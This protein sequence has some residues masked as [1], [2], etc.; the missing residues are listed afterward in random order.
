MVHLFKSDS[1]AT[2]F[3][4]RG[5]SKFYK[6]FIILEQILMKRTHIFTFKIISR[7]ISIYKLPNSFSSR[8]S[9]ILE[10]NS[11]I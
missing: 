9:V 10:Y 5:W 4:S 11:F 1:V 3:F 7:N 6:L 8:K 2:I